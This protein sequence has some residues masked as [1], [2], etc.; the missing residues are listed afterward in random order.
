[1]LRRLIAETSTQV[2]LSRCPTNMMNTASLLIQNSSI[3]E[4]A[5]LGGAPAFSQPLYVG[6]PNIGDR[7]RLFKRIE[8]A[9][10]RRWLSNG[11][12]YVKEFEQ[13]IAAFTGAKHCIVTCNGTLALEILIRALGLRGEVIVP[14]FTFI[15]TPHSLQWQQITPIFCD[16]DPLTH[17]IDPRKI[18]SLITPR[19]TGI[20][21]VHVWGR[22]CDID[23]LSDIAQAHNLKLAFD[24]SHA[25]G[26]SYKGEMIGNFG[27]A[28]VFSFHATKF[29]NAFEGGAIVTN[30]SELASKVRSMK[31]FG[32]PT[33]GDDIISIGTNGK[34]SEVSAAMGI[35][36]LESVQEFIET[37]HKNYLLYKAQLQELPGIK[38]IEFDCHEENNYQYIIL[39]IDP[40]KA[41]I[42]RD[43][44]MKVL[45]AENVLAKRYFFP[46]C[47]ELE[48]YRSYF[49]NAYLLLPETEKLT[50]KT[51]SLPTGTAVS[52]EDIFKICNIVRLAISKA[53]QISMLD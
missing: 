45:H 47:H 2:K 23:A 38:L 39:E 16:I 9:L 6:R 19:T 25:F 35:T 46:G 49:P 50:Q 3:D 36:G 27:E 28:E 30:N 52:E 42:S 32:Y 44:L 37:N 31:S 43:A 26:C 13:R 4:L 10:D 41:G 20:I 1:M 29:L 15:A 7:Q 17:N 18:E 40:R 11:G 51:L 48:P 12:I 22:P 33:S 14:S 34:M 5:I 21:G 8:D 53:D 24:A